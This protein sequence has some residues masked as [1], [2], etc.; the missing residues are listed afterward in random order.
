MIAGKP[1][2]DSR[3][4]KVFDAIATMQKVPK[5]RSISVVHGTMQPSI[6]QLYTFS[7]AFALLVR[8]PARATPRGRRMLRRVMPGAVGGA[9][10]G[11]VR[12]RTARRVCERK[13]RKPVK[14]GG[15]V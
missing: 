2:D 8:P 7:D 10:D 3:L 4:P 9:V 13:A 6:Q 11:G 12:S 15:Q 1:I 5:T 14:E